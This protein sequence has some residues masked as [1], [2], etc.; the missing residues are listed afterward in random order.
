MMNNLGS[1]AGEAPTSPKH[2]E[3]CLGPLS[4]I[5]IGEGRDFVVEDQTVAVFRTRGGGVFASQAACPH[6]VG[7]LSDGLLGGTTIVCPLHAWKF[8]LTT[9]K[10]LLGTCDLAVH[11]VR[12][13]ETGQIYLTL[14]DDPTPG[15]AGENGPDYPIFTKV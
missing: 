12:V 9:G 11:A 6:R 3:H 1:P 15:D 2:V 4:Q 14:Q 5:P 13:D 8:D 7:P 10:A